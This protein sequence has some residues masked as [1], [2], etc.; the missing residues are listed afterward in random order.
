[1]TLPFDNYGED[2]MRTAVLAALLIAGN[3]HAQLGFKGVA[4]GADRQQLLE[5]FASLQCAKPPAQFARLG[6][7]V[8]RERPC[9]GTA[10]EASQKALSTY[11]GQPLVD[12]NFGVVGGRVEQFGASIASTSYEGVRDALRAAHGAGNETTR[13]MQTLGGAGIDSRVWDVV[14]PGGTITL[15]ERAGRLDNGRVDARSPAFTQ[16]V[17]RGGDARKTSRDL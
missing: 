16:W 13:A 12:L 17:Q 14:V 15:F 7:E 3:A 4:L 11:G 5:Q 2:T 6:E 8:C 9:T 1:M 10:C